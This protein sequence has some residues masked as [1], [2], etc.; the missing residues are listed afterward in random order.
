MQKMPSIF[1]LFA[2]EPGAFPNGFVWF[3]PMSS[4]FWISRQDRYGQE[5]NFKGFCLRLV[6]TL[7]REWFMSSMN[8]FRI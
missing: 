2:G 1:S 8:V 6:V 7:S 5:N 3:R 4:D